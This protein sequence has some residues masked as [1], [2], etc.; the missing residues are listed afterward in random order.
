MSFS[1]I[2]TLKLLEYTSNAKLVFTDLVDDSGSAVYV[3]TRYT[4][5]TVVDQ[6]SEGKFSVAC[7]F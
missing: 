6:I 7:I 4:K 1:M 2:P 5:F 3:V